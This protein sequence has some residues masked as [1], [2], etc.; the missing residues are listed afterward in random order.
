MALAVNLASRAEGQTWPNPMVGAVIVKS[1]KI[2]G[3]G[4][5]QRWG[6]PHAEIHA[7]REAG[8]SAK[9]AT[10]YVTLE[11]CSHYGKTPPCAEAVIT[12]GIRT[13]VVAMKDPNPKVA[14]QGLGKL[15]R[16]GLD[17]RHGLMRQ[18]ARQLN[19]V[20]IKNMTTG[21]PY[22]ISKAAM[23][24]DGKIAAAD[25][26]S[27]WITGLPARRL[28]HH[29]RE[30]CQAVM[31]GAGTAL[32]DDPLLTVRHHKP[33]KNRQPLRVVIE[34]RRAL[35]G[36]ARLVKTAAASPLVIITSRKIHNH[37]LVHQ[38]QVTLWSCPGTRRQVD[39]KAALHR[40]YEHGIC[41]VLLE[42]GARLQAAFLGLQKAGDENLVDELLWFMAPKIMGGV[43]ALSVVA[44]EGAASP[45]NAVAVSVN[46]I[47]PVGK[48]WLIQGRV[49]R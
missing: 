7:L 41:C 24:L 19:R 46:A 32:L 14:G 16:A 11:P 45:Q 37:P 22:V 20:F 36:D 49:G 9:G 48:D 40:L 30:L 3:Q 35:A 27:Q 2:I 33:R 34:G 23:T 44:G 18:E 4:W 26:C 21:L 43:K 17:V 5:H 47:T 29:Y 42:G 25:G 1:G 39:L 12:A 15:R 28:T 6:G 13:V 10:L 8:T 38:P 31:V